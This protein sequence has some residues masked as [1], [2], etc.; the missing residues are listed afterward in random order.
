MS[1]SGILRPDGSVDYM[2]AFIQDITVRKKAEKAL[3]ESENRFKVLFESAPDAY[4]LN[5]FEGIFIDGNKAAENLLGYSREELIGKNFLNAGIIPK[6][7]IEKALNVLAKNRNGESSGPNE[8]I[9][10]KKDGTNVDVE[11]ITHPVKIGNKDI[12]LGIARDITER[13]QAMEE[14]RSLNEEL[15]QRIRERTADLQIS[16]QALVNIVEDLNMTAEELKNANESL[17]ELDRMKSM[18][19]ASTSHELRTPLN[20]I[21][22]FTSIL[23]EGWSGE[24]NS[25]Q[26]EQLG[27]VHTSGKHL[28]NL[29]NDVIDISKIEAGKIDVSISEF[30]LREVV[31]EVVS[32]V[33]NDIDTKGLTLTIEME[34]ITLISDRRRLLQSFLNL[35]SNAVKFTQRGNITIQAKSINSNLNISVTD[36]GIGVKHEDIPKLFT[37]FVR[38]ETSLTNS[39]AGTGLGLYLTKKLTEEALGGTVDVIS[40]YGKG[41]TFILNIPIEMEEQK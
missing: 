5:D 27:M 16:K 26:K 14:I 4:Y 15:E 40:E 19:I 8:Y 31:D 29:I 6:D 35:V 28:L 12:V 33:R 25:E 37:P 18:F 24:L 21:I 2:V 38:L 9:L 13:K 17:Q 41:S 20:S 3:R 7:K 1:V 23:L 10:K 34:D 32:V 22:G 30:K 11:I 39:T 36:S